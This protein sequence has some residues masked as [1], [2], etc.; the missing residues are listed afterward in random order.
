MEESEKCAN[1]YSS[2]TSPVRGSFSPCRSSHSPSPSGSP[3]VVPPRTGPFQPPLCAGPLPAPGRRC[4]R[5][6]Q[7]WPGNLRLHSE[8]GRGNNYYK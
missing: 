5:K 1:D 8:P 3:G 4:V 7:C 2:L 6:V